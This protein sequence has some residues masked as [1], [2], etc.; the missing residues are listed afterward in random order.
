MEN[1]HKHI[2]CVVDRFVVIRDELLKIFGPKKNKKKRNEYTFGDKKYAPMYSRLKDYNSPNMHRMEKCSR[3]ILRRSMLYLTFLCKLTVPGSKVKTNMKKKQVAENMESMVYA[4]Q[5]LYVLEPQMTINTVNHA[6]RLYNDYIEIYGDSIANDKYMYEFN[7][8]KMPIS[9]KESLMPPQGKTIAWYKDNGYIKL[10]Q[11]C[12]I[13]LEEE[14]DETFVFT[15]YNQIINA[16][17]SHVTDSEIL[18]GN[19]NEIFYFESNSSV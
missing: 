2:Q 12:I 17:K 4:L 5:A 3:C 8:A 15:G 14:S 10:I 6:E 16:L 7:I 13:K 19:Q 9:T 18:I 11:G 1:E